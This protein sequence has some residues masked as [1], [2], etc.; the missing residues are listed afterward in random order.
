[1]NTLFQF[2]ALYAAIFI[3]GAMLF[4]IYSLK[5]K[6]K[7]YKDLYHNEKDYIKSLN[8][9]NRKIEAIYKEIIQNY[10]KQI[11]GLNK[12]IEI[13]KSGIKELETLFDIK[14]EICDILLKNSSK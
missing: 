12:E 11:E 9:S 4:R 1:M 2:L 13:Y 7:F 6:V 3:I 8:E 5:S 14:N 10:L